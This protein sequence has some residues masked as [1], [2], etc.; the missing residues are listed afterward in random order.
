MVAKLSFQVGLRKRV[1]FGNLQ[2]LEDERIAQQVLGLSNDLPLHRQLQDP[3]LVLAR[4]EAKEERRFL[5]PLKLADGP[6][7]A[8]RL[9]L[10]KTAF[11]HVVDLQ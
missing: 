4:R 5:L 3:F 9:L 2:K 6:F 7:L 10:V 1:R 11:Q 8:N